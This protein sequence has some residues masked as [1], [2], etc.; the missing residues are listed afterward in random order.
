MVF[1]II[2]AVKQGLDASG[3]RHNVLSNNIANVNTPGFKRSDVNFSQVLTEQNRRVKLPVTRTHNQHLTS[4]RSTDSSKLRVVQE[5]GTIMG[6]D[7]NNVDIDR[8]MTLILENQLHYLAMT[9]IINRN[10]GFLR[11]AINEGRR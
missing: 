3:L 7:L 10:L 1:K 8:E 5:K 9:D 4:S 6:N 2:D 11:S